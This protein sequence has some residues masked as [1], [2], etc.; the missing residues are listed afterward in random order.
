MPCR[1]LQITITFVQA[2]AE[3]SE[4]IW[5]AAKDGNAAEV[6]RLLKFANLDAEFVDG[7]GRSA[8]HMAAKNGHL[9]AVKV[10]LEAGADPS[11]RASKG[12]TASI[13]A[14]RAGHINIV[15]EIDVSGN[16]PKAK[17]ASLKASSPAAADE[18]KAPSPT[19]KAAAR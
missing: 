9:D 10:L 12:I 11:L 6:E 14:K 2:T 15:K 1:P 5:V 4:A 18:T 16:K 17:A 7:V 8:L 13:M 19:R 3:Q